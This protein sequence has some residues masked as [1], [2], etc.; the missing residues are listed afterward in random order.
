MNPTID[1]IIHHARNRE[2]MS[3]IERDKTRTKGSGEGFSC[4]M[5]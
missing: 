3:G 5:C 1:R 4:I 2:Y